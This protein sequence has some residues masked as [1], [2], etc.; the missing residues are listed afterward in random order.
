MSNHEL[1]AAIDALRTAGAAAGCPAAAVDNEAASFVA[2]IA[3][4]TPAVA[5]AWARAFG[6]APAAFAGAAGAGRPWRTEPTPL[7]ARLAADAP[8][9]DAVNRADTDKLIANGRF[10]AEEFGRGPLDLGG[11][12]DAA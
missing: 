3:A 12:G 11:P 9:A 7:L 6:R 10:L 5:D 1:S 4:D 2:G 8:D